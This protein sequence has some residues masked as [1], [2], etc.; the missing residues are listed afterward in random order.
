MKK[1]TLKSAQAIPVGDVV[2]VING[3]IQFVDA[4]A[5]IAK[6]LFDKI[7]Q[8]VQSIG[9]KNPGSPANRLLRIEALEAKDLLQKE[10]NK[11]QNQVNEDFE[12]RIA[13]LEAS[14]S[15]SNAP[16]S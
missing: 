9:K 15:S 10:V 1:L 2:A 11:L 7:N 13:A 8:L 5:P 3:G 4:V 12:K 6:V 16:V 14:L